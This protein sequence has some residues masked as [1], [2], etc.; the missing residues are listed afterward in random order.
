MAAVGEPLLQWGVSS[1]SSG[2]EMI[3]MRSKC[4]VDGEQLQA[5]ITMN[6]QDVQLCN[7]SLKKNVP[8]VEL[9]YKNEIQ[10]ENQEAFYFITGNFSRK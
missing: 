2:C 3:I 5:G 7:G 1:C 9:Q 4:V 6:R 10:H 8:G